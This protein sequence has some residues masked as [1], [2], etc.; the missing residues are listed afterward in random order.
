MRECEHCRKLD[1]ELEKAVLDHL[2]TTFR[3]QP[4]DYL[5]K[6]A[7]QKLDDVQQRFNQHKATHE[8]ALG[9]PAC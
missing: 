8:A 1:R 7:K 5:T 2:K 6:A 3:H 9:L 4:D